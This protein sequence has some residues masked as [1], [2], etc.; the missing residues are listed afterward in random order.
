MKFVH[1]MGA[2]ALCLL[3]PVM[4]WAQPTQPIAPLPQE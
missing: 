4:A 2:L 1:V 3:L